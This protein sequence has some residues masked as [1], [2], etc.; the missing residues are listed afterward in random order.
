MIT[1]SQIL[2]LPDQCPVDAVQMKITG[3]FPRKTNIGQYKTSVQNA[4]GQDIAGNK[5]RL[6]VWGHA[7]IEPYKGKDIVLSSGP[8]GGVKVKHGKYTNKNGEE[9]KTVELEVSKSGQFQYVEVHK[10]QSEASGGVS[11][12][13]PG[14]TP[15]KAPEARNG[16]INP[17][18]G[19]TVG[20]AINQACSY[21]IASG[22]GLDPKAIHMIASD[23]VRVALVMEKGDLYEREKPANKTTTI[24]KDSTVLPEALQDQLGE[25]EEPF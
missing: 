13:T 24:L 4:E 17:I 2:T 15:Q 22:G 21:V 10:A 19:A 5:V 20:M 11:A 8:K 12:P 16:Q 9:V 7:D 6:C 25:Q 18:H 23:I 14:P 1:I 3:V